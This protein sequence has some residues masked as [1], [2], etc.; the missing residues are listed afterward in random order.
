[1]GRSPEPSVPPGKLLLGLKGGE[2]RE[3]AL[4]LKRLLLKHEDLS[5]DFH[6]SHKRQAWTYTL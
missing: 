1:M 3:V 6:N 2:A 4:F 5:S